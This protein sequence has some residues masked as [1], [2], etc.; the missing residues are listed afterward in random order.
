MGV[1]FSNEK[2]YESN[3]SLA[4]CDPKLLRN[5]LSKYKNDPKLLLI[6]DQIPHACNY[7]YN[8]LTRV[9]EICVFDQYHSCYRTLHFHLFGGLIFCPG[10]ELILSKR[11]FDEL[12][13]FCQS[14]SRNKLRK[15]STKYTIKNTI[16]S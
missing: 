13:E 4:V 5:M 9:T 2:Y 15:L 6:L 16:K 8:T 14:V 12:N 11:H 3:P 1:I 7:E 10:C